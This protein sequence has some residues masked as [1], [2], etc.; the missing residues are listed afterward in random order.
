MQGFS[1]EKSDYVTEDGEVITLELTQEDFQTLQARYRELYEDS[2]G[3][4]S[5][6]NLP[7]EIDTHLT[8]I[9]TGAI[10]YDYMNSRFEKYLKELR[11]DVLDEERLQKL[12]DEVHKSF[13]FLSQ[14]EQRYANQFLIVV[15]SGNLKYNICKSFHDY[16][17]DYMNKA[18]EGKIRTLAQNF[19]LDAELLKE[20]TDARLNENNIDEFGRYTRL[21]A[22]V[23]PVLAKAY[24]QQ[25][26]GAVLTPPKIRM[27]L[28]ALLRNFI[29]HGE[30]E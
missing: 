5:P 12:L 29:L 21:K 17:I 19:G 24:F 25:R 14:E 20:M 3:S 13:A 1:W 27:K 11:K 23:S 10:D 18:Q 8:E 2:S 22:S 26:E 9:E 30:I 7:Y 15:E 28:D 16:I 4:S 6:G